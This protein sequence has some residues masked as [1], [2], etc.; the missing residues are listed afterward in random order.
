M[1]QLTLAVTAFA[2]AAGMACSNPDSAPVSPTAPAAGQGTDAKPPRASDIPVTVYI[3]DFA[4]ADIS[5][6]AGGAYVHGQGGV[7]SVLLA[8][9]VNNLTNGDW[10]FFTTTPRLVGHSFEPGDALQP[11]DPGYFVPANPP[12]WGGPQLIEG[13]LQL[14]CTNEN[15]SMLTMAAADSFTCGLLNDFKDI[16]ATDYEWGLQMAPVFT[17]FAETDSVRVGCTGADAG[18][19]NAWTVEPIG[20]G[21]AVARL[22]HH[23]FGKGK[24]GFTKVFEGNFR[25]R[26]R[27]RITRP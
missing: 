1:R 16:G 5:S 25:L 14:K 13:K 20:G 11:G 15:H 21:V 3:D 7:S 10:K 9:A 6:D 2:L 8:N 26:F 24:S 27:I 22:V 17:G 19:C 4:G 18:G 23:V 12:F